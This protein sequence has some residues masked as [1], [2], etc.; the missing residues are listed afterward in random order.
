VQDIEFFP[1]GKG[2]ELGAGFFVHHR[3]V[4]AVKTAEFVIDT[5]SYIVLIVRKYNKHCI[6]SVCTE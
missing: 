3:I 2:N 1:D 4:S 6:E 5:M